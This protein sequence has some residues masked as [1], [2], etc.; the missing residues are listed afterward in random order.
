MNAITLIGKG[1]EGQSGKQARPER[2]V[3]IYKVTKTL[4]IQWACCINYD[5]SMEYYV[6]TQNH[7]CECRAA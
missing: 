6:V 3:S 4:D 7:D 5:N 1:R 2:M